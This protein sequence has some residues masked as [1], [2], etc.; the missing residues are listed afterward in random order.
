MHVERSNEHETPAKRTEKRVKYL[1]NN[2][3]VLGKIDDVVHEMVL[4]DDISVCQ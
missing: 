3:L 2:N 4:N 1:E